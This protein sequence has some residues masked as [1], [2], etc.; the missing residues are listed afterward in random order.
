M[1][2]IKEPFALQYATFNYER[3]V[4]HIHTTTITGKKALTCKHHLI[5]FFSNI[6]NMK[7]TTA[8]D[9]H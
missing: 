1:Q 6:C 7:F 5:I 4:L 8:S 9:V 2:K 3:Y